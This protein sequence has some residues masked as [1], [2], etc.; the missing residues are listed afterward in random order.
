[1]TQMTF[2]E[3]SEPV[4]KQCKGCQLWFEKTTFPPRRARC[5]KCQLARN[6]ELG[7]GWKSKLKHEYGITQE[8]HKMMYEDQSG[9]C[10]FCDDHRPRRGKSGLAIDHDKVTGFVRGLLCRPCNAN[11]VDEYKRLPREYQ[12]SPR[13][14]AYLRRGETGDYVESVKLRLASRPGSQ[15]RAALS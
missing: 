4:L 9:R 11:W 5:R 14:N 2:L 15:L 12:D 7:N 1:M 6:R 3:S 10:Y 8:I 13:T